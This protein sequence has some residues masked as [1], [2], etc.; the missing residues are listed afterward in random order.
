M[1][2]VFSPPFVPGPDS[3][4]RCQLPPPHLPTPVPRPD[5]IDL[6]PSTALNARARH[7]QSIW[8]QSVGLWEPRQT[9]PS[10]L[11]KSCSVFFFIFKILFHF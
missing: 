3:I 7:C 11:L 1:K 8:A 6:T 4:N 5:S 2:G 10:H 9:P